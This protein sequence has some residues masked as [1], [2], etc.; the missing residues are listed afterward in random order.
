MKLNS[1]FHVLVFFIAILT[2][3][4]PFG[5]LAQ[6]NFVPAEVVAAA[7]TDANKDVSKPLW[8]GTGCLLSGLVFV[9]LPSWYSCLLPPMGLTGTYFY[10]PDPPVSRLI[11]KSPEYVDIYTSAYKSK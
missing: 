7:E 11:G 8:F 2:F 4:L 5:T 10:Q 1:T 9:P 6:Q 3:S